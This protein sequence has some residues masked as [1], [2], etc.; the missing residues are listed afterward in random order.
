MVGG[1][2]WGVAEE[3]E[4][5]GDSNFILEMESVELSLERDW[6]Q[7]GSAPALSGMSGFL[8]LYRKDFTT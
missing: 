4:E 2:D 1:L 6:D 3:M 8:T 7:G 5:A